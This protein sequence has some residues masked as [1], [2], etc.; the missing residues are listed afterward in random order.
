VFADN[1]WVDGW[2][3]W[4]S[5]WYESLVDSGT[6][7]LPQNFSG[8]NFFPFYSWISWVVSLPL[9]ALLP[10]QSAFYAGGL[11][12]S[13][14]AF[15]MGLVAVYRLA[16]ARAGEDVA[17]R[18]IWLLCLFPF[19]FFFSAVY[20]DALY[21]CLAAWSFVFAQSRRWRMACA[22]A[23][24]AAMTRQPGLVLLPA[25][26]IEYFRQERPDRRQLRLEMTCGAIL[27]AGPVV[28][29]LY[30]WLRYGSPLAFVYARQVGWQR[31]TGLQAFVRDFHDFT[32]GS[33]VA[34]GGIVDCLRS[35]EAARLLA[36]YWY[37]SLIP[38]SIILV[39][40]TWRTLGPGLCIWTVGSVLAAVANGLDGTGRFTAVLFP[41]FIAFAMVV[42][43]RLF[44]AALAGCVPFLLLFLFQFSRWRPIL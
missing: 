29:A 8:A 28:L 26:V 7:L 23:A 22:A 44:A 31:A 21:L 16:A 19:S 37:L 24:L 34:C 17:R 38:A 4:D 6:R 3:R 10:M 32:A 30:F 12:V 15:L 43:G 42:R 35:W 18:A 20:A 39:C 25:L 11:I 2:V 1:N 13:Y 36:G 41:V 40:Y 27:A 9:R 14:V 33:L 5:M